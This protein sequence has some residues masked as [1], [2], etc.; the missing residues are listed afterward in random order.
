MNK[1]RQADSNAKRLAGITLAVTFIAI[2]TQS[3][4]ADDPAKL[5]K[6]MSDYTAAQKS[7]SATFDSDV[8]VV[9]PELEKIQFTS[10][11]KIQ[12]SR[13]DK[14]RISR[15][16]GYTD[17][18]FIYDGKTASIYGNN[19]KAY[20]QADL[21]GTVDQLVDLIQAK[22][23]VAMPGTDLLLT[24]AYDELMSNVVLAQH[25]GQGM[26]DGV[27]CEHL[28]FRGVD[29]DWQIWIESGAR[30]LPRKYV[31]TSKAVTGAPQYTLRIRDWKTDAVADADA[32]V[33]KPPAGVTKVDLNSGA[34]AE[35]DEIPPGTPS[36]ARK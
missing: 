29:T 34:M 22:S 5:L 24:N 14:L 35:F 10:S 8:E 25:I 16:G 31:I 3:A 36:G 1:G 2:T 17:V 7:I 19:A 4:R 27:E 15:T 21:V 12:L 9:T 33:F 28:A 30:P 6:T 11:G 13:P 23:G 18:D 20:V 26:I 32:F